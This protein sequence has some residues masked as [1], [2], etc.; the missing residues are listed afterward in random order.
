MISQEDIDAFMPDSGD[1]LLK[2]IH[3]VEEEQRKINSQLENMQQSID[4]LVSM[5]NDITHD[6]N[7]MGRDI[8]ALFSEI[9]DNR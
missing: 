6:I 5:V 8:V 7:S 9:G 4:V 1:P 3:T 2:S